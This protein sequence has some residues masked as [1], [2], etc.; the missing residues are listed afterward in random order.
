MHRRRV[1]AVRWLACVLLAACSPSFVRAEEPTA[2]ATPTYGGTVWTRPAL[3]GD[4]NGLRDR[5]AASGLVVALD[6]TYTFQ[7][8]TSGGFDG[9]LFRRLS[10]E[11]DTGNVFS[12]DLSLKLDTARAGL[13][14]GGLVDVQASAR[15]G[16]SVVQ[17]AG[18]VSAVDINALLPNVEDR[19][20]QA[21]LAVTA[22]IFTQRLGHGI[23]L[24]GGLL[25]GT[26]GD[27][28]EL[29]GSARGNDHFLNSA[30][31]YSLVE[32]ASVPNVS[33]GGGVGWV[34]GEHLSGSVSA[35]GASETA[36]E[37]PFER[38]HGTTVSTE[39]TLAYSLADRGGAQTFGALYGVGVS[40]TDIHVDPRLAISDL[41][42]GTP[43]STSDTDTWA[44]YYNAHQFVRGDAEGGWGPFARL[45]VS[46][47]NPNPVKWNAAAGL[48]GIGLLPGRRGD[49]WGLGAFYL[50][51]SNEK[52]LKGLGVNEEV[53]GELFY[54]V[55]VT[56]WLHVTVD[57]Q[58]ID[59][60]LPRANTACVFGLRTHIDL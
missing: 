36:G 2:P 43:V 40:R 47:G 53:G 3:T 4:W 56:P 35:F 58:A 1:P 13:W 22:F 29:A 28:N 10:D 31:L 52:L 37:N 38:W 16:R 25:N 50:G 59:A 18:T 39:W 27:A 5:W 19:F 17:R 33:L 23:A 45:G 24:F 34:P 32:D 15:A 11:G 48:G 42:R 49:R 6:A 57:V 55:G 30:L 8:V 26:E 7:T 41:L 60:A 44:L 12:S 9:P 20:D 51:M 21:A 14:Q 54:N 46:D